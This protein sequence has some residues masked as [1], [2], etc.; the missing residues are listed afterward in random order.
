LMNLP[1]PSAALSKE[2]SYQETRRAIHKLVDR[3]VKEE[4]QSWR[5]PDGVALKDYSYLWA[6]EILP[7]A[8]EA[9]ERLQFMRMHEIFDQG[10]PVMAGVARAI[11]VP[12]RMPYSD[13]SAKIVLDEIHKAGWR[14]ADLLTQAQ[15]PS[16]SS[17]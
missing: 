15:A 4:P 8:R 17:P 5:Q 7:V 11:P 3:L 10:R 16:T 14:L 12:D 13:W 1:E 6:D 2:E 9:H